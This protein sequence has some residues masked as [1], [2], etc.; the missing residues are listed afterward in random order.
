MRGDFPYLAADGAMRVFV[1]GATGLI[2]RR[3]VTALLARGDAVVALSRK[4]NA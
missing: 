2:G 1:T 4:A 3:L